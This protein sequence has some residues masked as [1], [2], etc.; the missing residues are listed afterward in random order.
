MVADW[1]GYCLETKFCDV[2]IPQTV[3]LTGD[4]VSV[5]GHSEICFSAQIR[6]ICD[7]YANCLHSA[8]R[9]NSS[10]EPYL[11]FAFVYQNFFFFNFNPAAFGIIT[12]SGFMGPNERYLMYVHDHLSRML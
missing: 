12:N 9:V 2:R 11:Y 7:W 1:K 5:R 8:S 3:M 4:N 6:A 10:P